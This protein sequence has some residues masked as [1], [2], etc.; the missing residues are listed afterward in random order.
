[1]TW[2]C[3]VAKAA[4]KS[5]RFGETSRKSGNSGGIEVTDG[6]GGVTVSDSSGD[7][8]IGRIAGGGVI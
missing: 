3:G 5:E 6:D 7:I 2:Q 8:A 4:S 1:M